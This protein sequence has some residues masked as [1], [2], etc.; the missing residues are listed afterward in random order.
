MNCCLGNLCLFRG[1]CCPGCCG[2]WVL[3]VSNTAVTLSVSSGSFLVLRTNNVHWSG[4]LESNCCVRWPTSGHP[5]HS[6]WWLTVVQQKQSQDGR[7]RSGQAR[8]IIH[9]G[10]RQHCGKRRR[11]NADHAN[12]RWCTIEE[13][14]FPSGNRQKGTWVSL[15]DGEEWNWSGV[16]QN[17]M[18]KTFSGSERERFV[19]MMVA[20]PEIEQKSRPPFGRR[21]TNR[22]T[23]NVRQREAARDG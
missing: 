2:V 7:I 12:S 9:D 10:R 14:D 6:H 22:G 19:D 11:E 21:R 18:T 5:C 15:E 1:L 3:S 23:G 16:R 17:K 8:N 4:L 20:P 13:S